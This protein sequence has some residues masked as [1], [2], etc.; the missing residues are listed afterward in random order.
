M[1]THKG[2]TAQTFSYLICLP[3]IYVTSNKKILINSIY[4]TTYSRKFLK[5]DLPENI[6][7]YFVSK[8]KHIKQNVNI[9]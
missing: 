4:N 5:V 7:C 9:A 2:T 8:E 3:I 1:A 6:Q